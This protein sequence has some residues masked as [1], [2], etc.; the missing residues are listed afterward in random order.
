[1]SRLFAPPRF[2]N[3]VPPIDRF[4]PSG[5]AFSYA[6]RGGDAF[7]G[8]Q[9]LRCRRYSVRRRQSPPRTVATSHARAAFCCAL[10]LRWSPALTF[11]G[12][13]SRCDFVVF[14]IAFVVLCRLRFCRATRS[15]WCDYLTSGLASPVSSAIWLLS[16]GRNSSSRIHTQ[17]LLL[18][19][20]RVSYYKFGRISKWPVL[21]L[22]IGNVFIRDSGACTR[23]FCRRRS[24]LK[25]SRKSTSEATWRQAR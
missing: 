3:G 10:G 11:V 9:R 6:E 22:P 8:S 1:M 24:K 7:P 18:A 5:N 2:R 4:V 13:C 20:Q 25:H 12:C 16:L 15:F 19:K 14:Y 21:I 23:R 17:F